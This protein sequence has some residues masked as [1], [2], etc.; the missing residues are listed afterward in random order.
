MHSGTLL[1]LK[2]HRF[3]L[4]AAV[5]LAALAGLA[6]GYVAYRLGSIA[7]DEVCGAAYFAGAAVDAE[8]SAAIDTFVKINGEEA[9][10]VFAAFG[11]L[12]LAV[13]LLAGV[14]I[15]GRRDRGSDGANR[16]G[17][18]GLAQPLASSPGLASSGG[19]RSGDGVRSHR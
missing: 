4:T 6:A 18:G 1:S 8:C 17:A 16:M 10:P 7:I 9:G 5:I 2:I 12:P 3:E 15:V 19:P 13:G 11:A 14:P